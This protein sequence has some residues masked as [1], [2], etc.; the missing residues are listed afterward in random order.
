[1][2]VA[3]AGGLG[4]EMVC[5]CVGGG[6]GRRRVPVNGS[7]FHIGGGAAILH[8]PKRR[9][10]GTR[11]VCGVGQSAGGNPSP[12]CPSKLKFFGIPQACRQ[13]A[14]VIHVTHFHGWKLLLSF[15]LG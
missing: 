3:E 11:S 14:G 6:G 9:P 7:S 2:V 8:L 13:Q 12:P 15:P 10:D 5:V 1:M 4:E